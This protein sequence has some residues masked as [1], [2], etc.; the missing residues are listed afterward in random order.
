MKTTAM[1]LLA[2][3]ALAS[4]GEDAASKKLAA[5]TEARVTASIQQLLTQ[6]GDKAGTTSYINVVHN[7]YQSEVPNLVKLNPKTATIYQTHAAILQEVAAN[8]PQL[9][10]HAIVT[11]EQAEGIRSGY[12]KLV[13]ESAARVQELSALATSKTTMSEAE[14]LKYVSDLAEKQ[15]H[16]L[17]LVKYYTKRTANTLARKQQDETNKRLMR[18]MWG[19][20]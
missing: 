5:D 19:H 3:L 14:Q 4:C 11:P 1:L 10:K 12:K 9:V 15:T 20:D 18:N 16:H 7:W 2:S 6:A 8:E 17:A 13:D